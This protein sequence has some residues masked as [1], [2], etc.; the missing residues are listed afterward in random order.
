MSI[1]RVVMPG[2]VIVHVFISRDFRRKIAPGHGMLF[3]IFA[4]TGPALEVVW[5]LNTL[6]VFCELIRAGK[7][8][9]LEW[10]HIEGLASA[11]DRALAGVHCD[12]RRIAV[13]VGIKTIFARAQN[14]KGKIRRV[15]LIRIVR[16][17]PRDVNFKR[18]LGQL[19]LHSVI[20]QVQE[21][22]ASL[23]S[24]AESGAAD[25]KFGARALIGPKIIASGDGTVQIC[26][27]P[28]LVTIR[29]IGN[30]TVRIAQTRHAR[31]RSLLLL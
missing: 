3:A 22:D 13:R 23:V 1:L 14:R 27:I 4:R 10:K 6:N 28:V 26:L 18:A 31:R 7:L 30:G 17:E 2:A 24:H 9:A 5:F 25:V 19:D 8:S 29:L 21:G 20:V 16:S 12:Y 15:D 11:S